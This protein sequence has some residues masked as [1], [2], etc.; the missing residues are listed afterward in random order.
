MARKTSKKKK[1]KTVK[2]T[3]TNKAPRAGHRMATSD[4]LTTCWTERRVGK[5]YTP[6]SNKPREGK[7]TCHWHNMHEDAAQALKAAGEVSGRSKEPTTEETADGLTIK[8]QGISIK[9][10]E[11]PRRSIVIELPPP[12]PP[13]TRFGSLDLDDDDGDDDDLDVDT[14]RFENLD[15]D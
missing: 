10:K 7:L 9:I 5:L 14:E 13:P 12:P 1:K 6:C 8:V 2:K 15:L 4:G 3:S 11:K